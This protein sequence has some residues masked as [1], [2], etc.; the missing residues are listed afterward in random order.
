MGVEAGRQHRLAAPGDPPRHRYRL[1]AGGRAVI[2]RGVGDVAAVKPRDLGLEFEQYLKRALGDFRLV[3]RVAGQKLATLDEM[4]DAGRDVVAIGAA[5][6]EEGHVAR[7]DVR[8]RQRPQLPLDAKLAGMIRQPR[9]LAGQPR[10]FGHVGEQ[11]VDRRRADHPQHV[12]PVG[13]G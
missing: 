7:R 3:G 1:P 12:T 6:Q 13:V 4:V 10:R 11:I 8:A 9:D 2:H 5:A